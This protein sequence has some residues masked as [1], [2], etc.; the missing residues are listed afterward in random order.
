MPEDKSRE[1]ILREELVRNER[2][3]D[4]PTFGRVCLKRPTPRKERLIAE[5]RRKQYHKDLQDPDILSKAQLENL[6]VNR[7]MWSRDKA[8]RL[9]DLSHKSGE[10]MG[11]L[12]G[13][14]YRSLED[15]TGEYQETYEK[16]SNL[17]KP[18]EGEKL[19]KRD[20]KSLDD[21]T[22]ALE[23]YFDPDE[24]P[25]P[26]DKKLI[27]DA[28]PST[29]VDDLL[30]TADRLRVQI[31]LLRDLS[32]IQKDLRELQEEQSRLFKDSLESRADR[33]EEL[34]QIY[35]C[36]T[37][38][39][40]GDPLWPEFDGILD[41]DPDDVETLMMEMFYFANGITEELKEILGRHGFTR[42]VL[43]TDTE[44]SSE[45]SP[46]H[47]TPNS[48]GEPQENDSTPSSE[49]ETATSSAAPSSSS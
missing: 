7:N 29:E 34:A 32:E 11:V 18:K 42:R 21:A 46:E 6:A 10:I 23:R 37:A 31:D 13:L 15:L 24:G 1:T 2:F 44:D 12:D 16:V 35:Y 8:D 26:T 5:V 49:P 4:H 14:G 43:E 20:Q 3:I 39:E 9:A 45:S 28:A 19:S 22:A 38:E 48:D 27:M 47:P 30:D 41:A 33:A 40:T 36:C 25:S 17:L